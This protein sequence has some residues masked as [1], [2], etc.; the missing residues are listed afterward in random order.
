[1]HRSNGNNIEKRRNVLGVA[2]V[3]TAA[4]ARHEHHRQVHLVRDADHVRGE[5][6]RMQRM[7]PL[8]IV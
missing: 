1:M 3:L 7:D 8:V 4:T 6:H 5:R 2:G